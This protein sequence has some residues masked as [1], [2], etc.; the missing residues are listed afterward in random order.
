[1]VVPYIHHLLPSHHI[2]QADYAALLKVKGQ[3]EDSIASL[4]EVVCLSVYDWQPILLSITVLNEQKLQLMQA[5]HAAEVGDLTQKLSAVTTQV[6]LSQLEMV[7]LQVS[8]VVFI[9]LP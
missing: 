7:A 5:A 4:S 3:A 1:M 6:D 8:I 9:W 2:T